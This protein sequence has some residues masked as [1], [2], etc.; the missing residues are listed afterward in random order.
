MQITS[1]GKPKLIER[2]DASG[3]G[4][5]EMTKEVEVVD[6]YITGLTGLKMKMPSDWCEKNV[7]SNKFRIGCKRVYSLYPKI[8]RERM[9]KEKVEKAWDPHHKK[10]LAKITNAIEQFESSKSGETVTGIMVTLLLKYDWKNQIFLDVGKDKL[11]KDNLDA[12]LDLLM[13]MDKKMRSSG[14]QNCS[15]ANGIIDT[16]IGPIFDVISYF[17]GEHWTVIINNT[18]D[19]D[20]ENA[21]VLRP[22]SIAQEYGVLT[23]EDSLN[24]SVN[25]HN[26]GDIVEIVGLCSSHG[27]HVASIAAAN[28]PENPDKNGLAPGNL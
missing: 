5:V 8:L 10:S 13:Q 14:G 26:D 2:I 24:V 7:K 11:V 4:D 21:L 9:Q 20:L 28:F 1:D 16:E 23:K 27:T 22:F 6:G 3:A 12:E 15:L 19:G 18:E 17:N 25:I